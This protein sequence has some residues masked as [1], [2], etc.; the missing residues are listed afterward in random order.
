MKRYISYSEDSDVHT[1]I[2][3]DG[4]TLIFSNGMV[5]KDNGNGIEISIGR[6]ETFF[7]YGEITD[8]YNAFRILNNRPHKISSEV[9][10]K[11]L[12]DE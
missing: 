8:I 1:K 7:D 5:I 11:E 3:E 9:I 4:D 2:T 12:K 10:Y 6:E